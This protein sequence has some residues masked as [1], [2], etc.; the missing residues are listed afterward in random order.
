MSMIDIVLSVVF[1]IFFSVGAAK[2]LIKSVVQLLGLIVTLYVISAG[3]HLIKNFLISRFSIEP[4]FASIASYLFIIVVIIL[5]AKLVTLI[6]HSVAGFLK[7]KGLNRFLGGLFGICYGYFFIA[8]FLTLIEI[9]PAEAKFYEK[10]P[11]SK[12]IS[13]VKRT[14]ANISLKDPRMKE[15]IQIP[16]KLMNKIPKNVEI[17]NDLIDKIKENKTKVDN[18]IDKKGN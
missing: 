9:S 6:L 15:M 8:L 1:V 17:N 11:D 16:Q 12:I 18:F 7:L 2:G 10:V 13:Y 14:K 3:G 4:L 5:M